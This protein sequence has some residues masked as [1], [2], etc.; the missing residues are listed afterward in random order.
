MSEQAPLLDQGAVAAVLG[1]SPRTLE[2]WR[3]HGG[4]PKFVK[5]G[6]RV[7][8]RHEDILEFIESRVCRNTADS[9][10][11]GLDGGGQR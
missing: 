10:Q 3:H 4:G 2:G 11:R 5:L 6:R 1:V 9:S 8:Y 7:V